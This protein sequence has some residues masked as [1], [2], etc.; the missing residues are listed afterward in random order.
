MCISTWEQKKLTTR[1][2]IYSVVNEKKIRTCF[3]S[4]AK[5]QIIGDIK[6]EFLEPVCKTYKINEDKQTKLKANILLWGTSKK[7]TERIRK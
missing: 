5:S 6:N 4:N 3:R 7:K 1:R 2:K